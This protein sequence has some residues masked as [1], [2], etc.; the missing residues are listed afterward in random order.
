VAVRYR[1]TVAYVR[2]LRCRSD[3]VR[4]CEVDLESHGDEGVGER[5]HEV[6]GDGGEPAPEDEL[7]ELERRVVDGLQVL[8]MNGQVE[9]EAEE[10]NDDKICWVLSGFARQTT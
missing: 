5:E 3:G 2:Y 4:V 9:G 10:G 6:G 8:H 1:I 7:R